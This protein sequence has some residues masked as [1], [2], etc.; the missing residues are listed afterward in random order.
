MSVS[1]SERNLAIWRMRLEGATFVEC[2]KAFGLSKA[3]AWHII[4]RIDQRL[5]TA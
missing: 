5:R 2:A 4:A 1:K 3:R